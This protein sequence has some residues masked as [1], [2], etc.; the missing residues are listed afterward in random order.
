MSAVECPSEGTPSTDT[1]LPE[2]VANVQM[3][4]LAGFVRSFCQY[5]CNRT[6]SFFALNLTSPRCSHVGLLFRKVEKVGL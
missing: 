1:S 5:S 4:P 3:F 2:N 6:T